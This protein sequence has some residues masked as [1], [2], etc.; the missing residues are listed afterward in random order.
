MYW[1][2]WGEPMATASETWASIEDASMPMAPILSE[3]RAK[4]IV[5][6]T[7]SSSAYETIKTLASPSTMTLRSVLKEVQ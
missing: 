1:R 4:L 5:Q 2:L 3:Y 6:I 7:R